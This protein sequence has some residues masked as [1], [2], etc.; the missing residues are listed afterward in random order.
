[1]PGE[2][3][4]IMNEFTKREEFRK[5]NPIQKKSLFSVVRKYPDAVN[6]GLVIIPQNLKLNLLPDYAEDE[7]GLIDFIKVMH[8]ELNLEIQFQDEQELLQSAVKLP[9]KPDIKLP[10]GKFYLII[11]DNLDIITSDNLS[12]R[13]ELIEQAKALT[14]ETNISHYLLVLDTKIGAVRTVDIQSY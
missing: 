3:S 4:I 8:S 11:N 9:Q 10:G 6:R 13:K 12:N 2:H 7:Q 14:V 1:M 5:L